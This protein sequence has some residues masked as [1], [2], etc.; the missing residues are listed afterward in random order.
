MTDDA[1]QGLTR[2]FG[3]TL[4][5]LMVV[6][7]LLGIAAAAAAW[8]VRQPIAAARAELAADRLL[9]ADAAARTL[10]VRRGE[11]VRLTFDPVAGAVLRGEAA[12][13]GTDVAEAPMAEVR[14]AGA[15]AGPGPIELTVRPDGSSPTYAV[16]LTGV[17][18][19][20]WLLVAGGTGRPV[21][22]ADAAAVDA[23]L[24]VEGN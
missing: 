23:L 18:E 2:R 8:S 24:A 20:P 5:E 21:R 4:V 10:A 15:P 22:L 3:F 12:G 14:R 6:C 16:R 19:R 7:A 17:G 1:P 13:R 9:A 11:A